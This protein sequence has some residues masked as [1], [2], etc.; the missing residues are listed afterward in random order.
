MAD[1]FWLRV[2]KSDG[3]WEWKGARN[4][5]RYGHLRRPRGGMVKAHRFSWELHNGRTVPAGIK[6]CHACDNPP[7][8][9]PDHLFLG[10]QLQ[11]VAD[12][13]A[14]GRYRNGITERQKAQTH[15]KHGHPFDAENTI[16]NDG[17]RD[18]RACRNARQRRRYHAR[19]KKTAA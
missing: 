16:T 9:R 17:K 13:L 15:C 19:R 5:K 10:T 2:E 8:V 14:K 12:M 6:V 1:R 7:C 3:C 11:N 4:G 18:C